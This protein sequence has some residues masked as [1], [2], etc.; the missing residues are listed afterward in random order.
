M[1][2]WGQR[3]FTLLRLYVMGTLSAYRQDLAALELRTGAYIVGRSCLSCEG[4][5]T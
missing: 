4:C 1:Y 2:F 3:R 5:L